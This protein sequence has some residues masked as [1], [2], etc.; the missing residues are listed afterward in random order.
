MLIF[1]Y[2]PPGIIF[3][4]QELLYIVTRHLVPGSA[5]TTRL[6]QGIAF[7]FIIIILFRYLLLC[8]E[9]IGTKKEG[10]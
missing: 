7:E 8:H 4:M 2:Y 6:R 9:K 3:A 5:T 10:G 1:L